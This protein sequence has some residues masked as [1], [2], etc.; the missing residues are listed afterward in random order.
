MTGLE[1]D[2]FPSKVWAVIGIALIG[3]GLPSNQIDRKARENQRQVT[4]DGEP[5]MSEKNDTEAQHADKQRKQ[6]KSLG[7]IHLPPQKVNQSSF[8]R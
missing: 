1:F 7:V 5:E 3:I 8:H 6:L 4:D 2:R